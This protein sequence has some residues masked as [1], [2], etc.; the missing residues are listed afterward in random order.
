MRIYASR[1][2]HIWKHAVLRK[3]IYRSLWSDPPRRVTRL[4]HHLIHRKHV[5]RRYLSISCGV[6]I[7]LKLLHSLLGP[8][9]NLLSL[10][11]PLLPAS[12]RSTS[13]NLA[14]QT[15][16]PVRL[17]YQLRR[18]SS[19]RYSPDAAQAPQNQKAAERPLARASRSLAP[20]LSALDST[21]T[22]IKVATARPTA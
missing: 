17:K 1:A 10:E 20:D 19:L 8:Q 13:A 5:Y 6:V 14:F 4:T 3:R 2:F 22:W 7:D 12:C 21:V 16:L 15:R 9:L 18:K 11:S